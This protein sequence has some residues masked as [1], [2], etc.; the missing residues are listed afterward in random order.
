MSETRFAVVRDGGRI[1]IL[2]RDR[3]MFAPFYDAG[4][5]PVDQRVRRTVIA[6]N[7]GDETTTGYSWEKPQSSHPGTPTEGEPK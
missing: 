6:L 7:L 3:K 4:P 5:T 1:G 2:D